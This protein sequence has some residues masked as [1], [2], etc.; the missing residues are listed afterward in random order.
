[1]EAG[2]VLQQESNSVV[3]PPAASKKRKPSPKKVTCEVCFEDSSPGAFWTMD[4]GHSFCNDCWTGHF[5]AALDGGNK[6]IRCMA[7]KCPAICDEDVVR[8]LLGRRDPAAAERFHDFLLRSYVDD[9][10]A[11]KWCPSVPHCGRAIRLAAADGEPPVCEAECPCGASFCFRCAAPAHSPCPCAMWERWEAKGRGEA[12]NVKWLL[13]NTK[14]CPK[15]FKPIIKD[16]G[17]NL[18]TCKCGQH[19]CWLCGG[20]T[21]LSHT[22]TSIANHSCN[23]FEAEEKKKVDDAK[24][25]VR[26]YEHYYNRFQS[27]GVSCRAEREQLGPAVAARAARLESHGGS[28][29]TDT[30]WLGNAYRSL[31]GCRQALTRSYVFA[32]YMFDGEE[33]PTRPLEPGSLSM[34]QRQDLFEDYQEQV[35]ANVERLSKLLATDDAAE[36]P[37]EEEILRVRQHAINLTGTVEKLCRQMYSCIQEKLLPMLVEPMSIMSYQPGGPSKAN[38]LPA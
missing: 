17:C 27:H 15:C 31:L 22:W 25:Q 4:C 34:A 11:V 9:N 29:I 18:V 1:M 26:R 5:V 20:A 21:G 33:T 23:R 19:L 14:S 32:Y 16:G 36:L 12:E 2:V 38:E 6:Q 30:S 7:F 28:L 24:R 8:R 37:E 3:P 13:A 10:S 35:E